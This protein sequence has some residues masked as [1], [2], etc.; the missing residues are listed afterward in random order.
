MSNNVQGQ[1]AQTWGHMLVKSPLWAHRLSGKRKIEAEFAHIV[2]VARSP[3]SD[4]DIYL[5]EKIENG[6]EG[7]DVLAWWKSKS[8]IFLYYQLWRFPLVLYHPNCFQLWG[9]NSWRP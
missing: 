5:E 9:K 6:T 3:K 1:V 4:L 7:F 2:R 8:E